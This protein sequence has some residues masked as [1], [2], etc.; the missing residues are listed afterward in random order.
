[1]ISGKFRRATPSDSNTQVEMLGKNRVVTSHTVSHARDKK[2]SESSCS[3]NLWY[4]TY[5]MV[6][7]HLPYSLV[8][9]FLHLMHDQS[10]RPSADEL[11][12][13]APNP[14]P[15]LIF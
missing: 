13:G 7:R 10:V 12:L 9:R 14:S 15:L 4:A 3:W 11:P 6:G 2:I 8:E 1:M 5:C